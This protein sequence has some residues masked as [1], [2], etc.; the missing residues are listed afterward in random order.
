MPAP[1]NE[2]KYELQNCL[3]SRTLKEDSPMKRPPFDAP[4]EARSAAQEERLWFRRAV[5]GHNYFCDSSN[6]CW[7]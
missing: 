2:Y 5:P 1:M 6:P 4:A 7:I 3:Q